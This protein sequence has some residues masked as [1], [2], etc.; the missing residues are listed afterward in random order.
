M[1]GICRSRTGQFY[2]PM[3]NF[4]GD[5]PAAG[6]ERPDE[7]NECMLCPTLKNNSNFIWKSLRIHNVDCVRSGN[8]RRGR[9][10]DD[11]LH[12]L[13]TLC[14]SCG[15]RGTWLAL[16]QCSETVHL[17]SGVGGID[18][19]ESAAVVRNER[20]TLSRHLFSLIRR[21]E[22]PCLFLAAQPAERRLLSVQ[23]V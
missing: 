20:R 8:W 9:G 6:A 17:P 21:R 14:L 2:T 5:S 18:R 22:P 1:R 4:S 16:H 11:Q 13:D 19:V 15:L 10:P 23:G 3:K 12:N 7:R